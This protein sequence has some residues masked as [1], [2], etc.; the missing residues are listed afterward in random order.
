MMHIEFACCFKPTCHA[1][2]SNCTQEGMH[3]QSK[4]AERFPA[5][6]PR[7]LDILIIATIKNNN[8]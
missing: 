5:G 2:G 4:I 8:E 6:L 1:V 3:E 7:Y